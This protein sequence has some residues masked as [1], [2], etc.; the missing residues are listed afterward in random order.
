MLPTVQNFGYIIQK[1]PI[2]MSAVGQIFSM[3]FQKESK[4]A[5]ILL[6]MKSTE[7]FTNYTLLNKFSRFVYF[8]VCLG[9]PVNSFFAEGR[10]YLAEKILAGGGST[11]S[12]SPA[13]A[14]KSYLT[15]ACNVQ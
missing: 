2:K 14:N 15:L 6:S 8:F 13:Q 12:S 9:N 3:V 1:G 10:N 5:R 7:R 4:R 11:A